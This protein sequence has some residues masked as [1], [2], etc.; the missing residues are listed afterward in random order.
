MGACDSQL[1]DGIGVHELMPAPWMVHAACAGADPAL[2]FG[3]PGSD[4][5][6]AQAVCARCP[7]RT[8]CLDFAIAT[9]ERFGIWGGMG[10]KA[11]HNEAR[12][13]RQAA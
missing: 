7:V 10:Q 8:D 9:H 13:R 4:P 3:E 5:S 12:R 1:I 6:E 11:R 2:F